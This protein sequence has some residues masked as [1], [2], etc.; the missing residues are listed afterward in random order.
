MAARR[1]SGHR[2]THLQ[3]DRTRT[4]AFDG[5]IDWPECQSREREDGPWSVRLTAALLPANGPGSLG[6]IHS[7]CRG[8]EKA[9]RRRRRRKDVAARVPFAASAGARL[10][11]EGRRDE[12]GNRC[13]MHGVMWWGTWVCTSEILLSRPPSGMSTATGGSRGVCSEH[14]RWQRRLCQCSG[15][16]RCLD[17]CCPSN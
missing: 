10:L 5:E 15:S 12:A 9:R 1:L 8:H 11:P 7:M 14:C 4:E 2:D 13:G 3:P 6:S 17:H 16:F